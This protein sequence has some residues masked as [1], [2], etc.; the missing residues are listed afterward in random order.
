MKYLENEMSV[1]SNFKRYRAIMDQAVQQSKSSSFIPILGL[2]LK[3]LLF[4]SDGNAKFLPNGHVNMDRLQTMVN[5]VD[6]LLCC[7]RARYHLA[8]STDMIK[9]CDNLFS[10]IKVAKDDALYKLSLL[11]EA[12]S[13]SSSTMGSTKSGSLRKER[14]IEKWEREARE[15]EARDKKNKK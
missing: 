5:K 11:N 12:R 10:Q 2:F 3:D 13:D 9:D 14:M 6:S 4:L 1:A 7:Q 15:Q 8:M